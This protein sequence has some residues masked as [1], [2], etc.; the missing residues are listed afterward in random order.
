METYKKIKFHTNNRK[1][2]A[3]LREISK[4][5][6]LSAMKVNIPRRHFMKDETI[7]DIASSK[8]KSCNDLD[9]IRN[10]PKSWIK[11][12]KSNEIIDIIDK[13]DNM[14]QS[15]Y[16]EIIKTKSLNEGQKASI[17]LLKSLLKECAKKHNISPFLIAKQNDL[18]NFINNPETNEITRGWKFEIFGK[19]AIKL[20]NGKI[21]LTIKNQRLEFIDI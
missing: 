8:I 7:I 1:V 4:W 14:P 15:D 3:K 16:P 9:K 21:A 13:V 19:K 20:I 6:E 11:S 10:F 17:D 12:E 5:R 2:L 18:E